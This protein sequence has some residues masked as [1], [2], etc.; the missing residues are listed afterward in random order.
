MKNQKA[1]AKSF[2]KFTQHIVDLNTPKSTPGPWMITETKK[3]G[4]F[5]GFRVEQKAPR[6][7]NNPNM[8]QYHILIADLPGHRSGGADNV[9]GNGMFDLATAKTE[10]CQSANARLIAAAPELLEAL[11]AL[12]ADIEH[13]AKDIPIGCIGLRQL[14]AASAAIA[15]AEGKHGATVE[16]GSKKS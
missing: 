9:P 7:P 14:R 8:Q 6:Y 16:K 2:E 15:K 5:T 4:H 1:T 10:G 13:S 12:L 3:R 11:E